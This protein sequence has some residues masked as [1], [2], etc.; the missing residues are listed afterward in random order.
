MF[1]HR[2]RKIKLLITGFSVV[3]ATL[4]I[5]VWANFTTASE[6]Q[7]EFRP[8][9]ACGTD[10]GGLAWRCLRARPLRVPVVSGD[11]TCPV[12][13]ASGD[14]RSRGLDGFGPAWGKGPG[15]PLIISAI[16]LHRPT[17]VF[18]SARARGDDPL[19]WGAG[20][21]IWVI[22]SAYRGPL[23]I[24]GRQLDGPSK[25]FFQSGEPTF[26]GHNP[27]PELRIRGVG[28]HPSIT[29]VRTAG[30]FAY[31]LDGSRFTRIIVFEAQPR[32]GAR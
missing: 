16:K 2:Q 32:R 17:L 9:I 22:D 23:L 11:S 30:C 19:T 12:S 13:R 27:E 18:N 7:L 3:A 31:Q 4:M 8:D 15:Y 29:R 5:A 26:I 14:L 20:K 21:V 25:V 10:V 6:P 28:G 24:R 1:S